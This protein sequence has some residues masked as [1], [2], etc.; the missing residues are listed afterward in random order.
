MRASPRERTCSCGKVFWPSSTLVRHCSAACAYDARKARLRKPILCPGC[1]KEL[2]PVRHGSSF[3]KFCSMT[4]RMAIKGRPAM[5]EVPCA[6]CGA[7]FKRTAAAI[8]RVKHSFCG[9][10]CRVKF[11]VGEN[12][13]HW[14]GGHDANRGPGWRALAETIRERDGWCCRRCGKAQTENGQKLSVDHVIPWRAFSSTAGANDPGN[15]VSLCRSCHT[16][17]TTVAERKWLQG[18]VLAMRAYQ[19]AVR[20]AWGDRTEELL[21]G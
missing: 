10:E 2:W 16:I 3:Q 13:T 17:K 9:N 4:C 6:Q 12:A 8:R 19:E 14:R 7:V 20:R 21:D 1:G 5:V 11:F 15:L 18:D